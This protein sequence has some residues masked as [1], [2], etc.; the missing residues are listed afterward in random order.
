M[1][2]PRRLVLCLTLALLFAGGLELLQ[3][4]VPGRHARLVDFAVDTL[5]AWTGSVAAAVALV[6]V[7]A[8][9]LRIKETQQ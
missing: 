6:C 7:L 9:G 8:Q 3:V 4:L 5:G 2:Y 1:G